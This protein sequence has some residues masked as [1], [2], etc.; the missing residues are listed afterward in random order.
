MNGYINDKQY[1][2]ILDFIESPA[3]FMTSFIKSH[4][5]YLSQQIEAGGKSKERALLFM[6]KGFHKQ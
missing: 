6:E 5:D 1:G 4:P 2:M 3:K